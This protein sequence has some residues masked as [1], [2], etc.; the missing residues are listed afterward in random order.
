MNTTAKREVLKADLIAGRG[1]NEDVLTESKKGKAFVEALDKCQTA[2]EVINLLCKTMSLA[3]IKDRASWVTDNPLVLNL[4]KTALTVDIKRGREPR[5]GEMVMLAVEKGSHLTKGGIEG[6]KD[7]LKKSI[8][9]REQ[10]QMQMM[11][12]TKMAMA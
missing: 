6:F 1:S 10:A 2:E 12:Q 9:A 4:R 5:H 3:T 11:A 7:V 8:A